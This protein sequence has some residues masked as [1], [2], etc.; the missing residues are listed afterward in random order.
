[1]GAPVAGDCSGGG[2]CADVKIVL[3]CGGSGSA[4]LG[5]GVVGRVP[6]D[7]EGDGR[8]LVKS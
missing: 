5:V 8:I 2:R 4:P 1:M 7:W 3:H 6:T